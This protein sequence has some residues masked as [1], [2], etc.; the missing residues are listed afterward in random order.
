MW[1]G[2]DAIRAAG[3]SGPWVGVV[4][5]RCRLHGHARASLPAAGSP[6]TLVIRVSATDKHTRA[7]TVVPPPNPTA[8]RT[9]T[10]SAAPLGTIVTAVVPP[11][12]AAPKPA[13]RT[14]SASHAATIAAPVIPVARPKPSHAATIAAP[15]IPV[16]Q[17]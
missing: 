17:S 8:K 7:V 14:P 2:R 6:R 16:A 1:P 5:G 11:A 3:G 9:R 10:G 15:V 12:A 4:P 13:R